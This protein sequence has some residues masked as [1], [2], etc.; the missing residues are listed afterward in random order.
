MTQTEK[1]LI[2]KR[3]AAEHGFSRCGISTAEPL[4]TEARQLQRWLERGYH[5]EMN[6]MQRHAPLRVDPSSLL[7]GVKSVIS[8]FYNYYPDGG[9]N[10]GRFKISKYAYGRDYH[11]VLRKKLRQMVAAIEDQ[12][13][14]FASRICIDSAP[15]ME[16]SWAVRSGIGWLGKHTNVI[17]PDLGSFHFIATL[18]VDLNLD[19]DRPITDHCGS[20]RL[21]LDACPTGA[22][23]EPYVVDARKCISYLTIEVKGDL[24]QHMKNTYRGWIFGCDICQD[25]CPFNKD[26]PSHQEPEFRP[27]PVLFSMTKDDWINIDPGQFDDIFSG[28]AVRRAGYRGLKRNIEFVLK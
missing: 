3:I 15:I 16:K 25:V 18:L 14:P 17:D 1:T 21:C 5:G 19:T 24:P 20:C 12:I 28:S 23:V 7:P 9:K 10:P 11:K 4:D 6:Y 22:I 27:P 2:I 26:I 13:G 8:L